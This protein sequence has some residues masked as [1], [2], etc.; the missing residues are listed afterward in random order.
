MNLAELRTYKPQILE[1]A[2]QY[3][4]SD[5]RVFGSVARGDADE[6]SDVD[7]L[8][9]VSDEA[10]LI[11]LVRCRRDIINLCGREVDLVEDVAIKNPRMRASIYQ[12]VEAL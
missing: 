9:H 2:K 1:I 5:I 12:D 6:D 7:L 3:G 11:D 4:V 8:V 10:S